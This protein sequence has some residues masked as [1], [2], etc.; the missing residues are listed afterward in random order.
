MALKDIQRSRRR[1]GI[2]AVMEFVNTYHLADGLRAPESTQKAVEKSRGNTNLPPDIW[3]II[4]PISQ[5][6][7]E[8]NDRKYVAQ[9][10][11][12]VEAVKEAL[13]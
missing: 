3:L 11:P 13:I 8:E 5:V 4:G 6:V 10:V 2:T 12:L 1:K 9:V 7:L